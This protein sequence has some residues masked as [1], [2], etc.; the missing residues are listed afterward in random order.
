MIGGPHEGSSNGRPTRRGREQRASRRRGAAQQPLERAEGEGS[1]APWPRTR[2]R[3][4][5]R[6]FTFYRGVVFDRSSASIAFNENVS[7]WFY[8]DRSGEIVLRAEVG[9]GERT[10]REAGRAQA[11]A[12]RPE[13]PAD[14]DG[15]ERVRAVLR[16]TPA[17]VPRVVGDPSLARKLPV[18]RGALETVK[19]DPRFRLWWI[20]T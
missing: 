16:F 3:R 14:V 6:I 9:Y 7:M 19:R 5:R 15:A 17:F 10:A 18:Q 1:R 12:R 2:S 4:Q 8:V 13:A 20:T 11:P